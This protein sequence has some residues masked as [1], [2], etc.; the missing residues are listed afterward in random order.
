METQSRKVSREG[1]AQALQHRGGIP[2]VYLLLL[3]DVCHQLGLRD[4]DLLRGL[5]TSR[6]ALCQPDSQVSMLTAYTATRRAVDAVGDQG[7]GLAYARAF[8]VTLMGSVG[9]LA[10]SSPSVLSALDAVIRFIAL[11]TPFLSARFEQNDER[12]AVH[13]RC[14]EKLGHGVTSFVMEVMLVGLAIILEQMCGRRMPGLMLYMACPEPA[15]FRRY[16]DELPA[17][18]VFDAQSWSL[19]GDVAV[20]HSEPPLSNPAMEAAAREQ[21]EQEYMQLYGSRD[22][23]TGRIR[24]HLARC[25]SGQP[26]PG[27]EQFAG[28][29][30]VSPRTLKRRLQNE[31]ASYR[32]LVDA[33]LYGRAQRLLSCE[34][35]SISQVG[36]Q[37]GYHEA[38]SFSRA[39]SRWAGV[40]PRDY[41]KKL[42][43]PRGATEPPD[44]RRM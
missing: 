29:L 13:I 42:E 22:G 17:P 20:F 6:V 23:I 8:R 37:L 1:A 21:C 9:L 38:A 11:R 26:L 14:E 4:A 16:A 2:G 40:S 28:W 43:H 44:K 3:C 5:G 12:V 41:R 18:V 32:E 15:Y 31:G 33:E 19:E 10:L 36:Y 27:L 34:R 30:G 35:L 7:L 25:E 24:D 39:F